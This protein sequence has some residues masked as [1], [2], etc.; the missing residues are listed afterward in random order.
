MQL[1]N[2]ARLV[3][4]TALAASVYAASVGT[5]TGDIEVTD[6]AVSGSYIDVEMLDP[7]ASNGTVNVKVPLA[8]FSKDLYSSLVSGAEN[9]PSS[10]ACIPKGEFCTWGYWDCC[11]SAGCLLVGIVGGVCT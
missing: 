5:S 11:G 8:G 1:T 6:A 7:T 4:L 10:A 2:F 9:A 3:S